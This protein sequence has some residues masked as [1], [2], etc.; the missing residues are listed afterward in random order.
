MLLFYYCFELLN[1]VLKAFAYG[2]VAAAR[3]LDVASITFVDFQQDIINVTG[4]I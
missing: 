4:F 1:Y 2:C 3:I